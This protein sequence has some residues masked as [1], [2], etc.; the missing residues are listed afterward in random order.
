MV[1]YPVDLDE[2]INLQSDRP[3]ISMVWMSNSKKRLLWFLLAPLEVQSNPKYCRP[4]GHY[5]I[6]QEIPIDKFEEIESHFWDY[7]GF[8]FCGFIS[9]FISLASILPCFSNATRGT[10]A[11]Y[12]RCFDLSPEKSKRFHSLAKAAGDICIHWTSLQL[13]TCWHE[14]GSY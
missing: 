2:L 14:S 4:I 9:G 8:Y 11:S 10:E 5:P 12:L 7:A 3:K 1:F 13:L 6:H